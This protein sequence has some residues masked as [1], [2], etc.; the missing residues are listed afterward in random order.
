MDSPSPIPS[1]TLHYENL[2]FWAAVVATSS[3]AVL[4]LLVCWPFQ[5]YVL[6]RLMGATVV[7]QESRGIKSNN[8][9]TSVYGSNGGGNECTI[10]LEEFKDSE[11][12]RVF[13]HCNHEFHVPCID[14]WLERQNQ[15]CPV[16]RNSLE[17]AAV[18]NIVGDDLV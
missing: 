8:G 12:C 7:R 14:A 11:R 18:P 3:V 16:C 6:S 10:C 15:S 17:D 2:L 9:I 4:L 1:P 5:Y 13:P